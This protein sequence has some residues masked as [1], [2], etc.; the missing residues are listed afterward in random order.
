MVYLII[1][2]SYFYKS[3]ADWRIMLIFVASTYYKMKKILVILLLWPRT[4]R[5]TLGPVG[6]NP[7]RVFQKR[8]IASS[9]PIILTT[10]SP[11]SNGLKRG[12]AITIPQ[13]LSMGRMALMRLSLWEKQGRQSPS[14]PLH[15]P[16]PMATR[17][18][19]DGGSRMASDRRRR[20]SAMSRLR[21]SK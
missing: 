12:R 21:L 10:S 6:R 13:S 17:S 4:Q 9:I 18:L 19:S 16:T 1:S 7:W 14:M 11:A 3:L 8:I 5:P 15:H 2:G 20:K